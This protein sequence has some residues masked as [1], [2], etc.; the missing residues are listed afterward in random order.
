M[1]PLFVDKTIEIQAPASKVWDALTERANTDVWAEE[2][3]SGGPRFHIESDWTM[4]SRVEWKGDDGAVLVEGNVTALIPLK[5]LR[6]TV[7]DTRSH[8]KV[9]MNEKDGI[10]YELAEH[11]G[12]T[13]LHLLQGDFSA[14]K[15]GE[16]YC[17]LTDETWERVLPVIQK[18]AEKKG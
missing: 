6:Y 4:G 15:D 3:S 8:E 13:T 5:F 18:L 9:L 17:R 12:K 1:T 11:D 7:G 10:T 2:F 14:M 16:K